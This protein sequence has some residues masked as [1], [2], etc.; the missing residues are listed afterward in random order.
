[1]QELPIVIVGG[2][3]IGSAIAYFLTLQQPG[4]SV[5]VIERDPS[6][7]QASSALSASSIRQQ[8]STAIN[9]ALSQFGIGF[10]RN[11]KTKLA[12]GNDQPDIGL[13][14]DGYLYL[15][16]QA[17][18]AV[19]RDN[20]ALQRAHDVD[21]ALLDSEALK[22]RFPWLNV[23]D[24][25]LGSLGLSAEGWFDGYLL[26]QSLKA[27]AVSQGVKYLRAE[28]VGVA[29]S[30]HDGVAHVEAVLLADGTRIACRAMVNAAGAWAKPVAGWLDIDLPVH[31]KRRTVFNLSS[32]AKLPQ[33]PLLIDPSGIWLRPEGHGFIAGFCPEERDDG[34]DIPLDVE[35][36]A[37]ENFVWPTLAERIPGFEAL[38][39]E[40]AWA[41]YYEMNLFDHN[42]IIGL[43]PSCDNA[44]FANGFSGHG[45]QQSPAA[46]RAI[47]ELVLTGR[48]QTL[49]V[50]PLGWERLLRNEP[51]L[52][53][54]I[55]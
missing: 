23:D 31:G 34:N 45:L 39:V 44:Y 50:S 20:H 30:R 10:L 24:I 3:A 8:F 11:L 6:Y 47:A 53:K 12:V 9:I 48:Y 26:M 41:G 17:G 37:F 36:D 15:A 19:L 33:C 21:V 35:H 14:E 38:R 42:A 27:K 13:V 22:A 32:P 49:D 4:V 28:A 55:I 2:G 29:H 54:C 51:L 16:T 40:S 43:H 52:E 1:M 46:G 7:A 18:E 5:M 25:V